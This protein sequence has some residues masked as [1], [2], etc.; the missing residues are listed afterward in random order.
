[1]KKA[2]SLMFLCIC[3]FIIYQYGVNFLKTTHTVTYNIKNEKDFKI[4]ESFKNKHYYYLITSGEYKFYFKE[5][6]LFNKTKHVIKDIYQKEENGMMCI[7][8]VYVKG[9]STIICSDKNTVYTYNSVKHNSL[10][11]L[12]YNELKNQGYTF[13][14]DELNNNYTQIGD[15]PQIKDNVTYYSKNF[16]DKENLVLWNYKGFTI[17]NKNRSLNVYPLSFDRYENTISTLISK[18]YITP[19][20][21]DNKLFNFNKVYIYDILTHKDYELDLGITLSNYTY[22]NGIVDNKLYLFDS[23]KIIQ[24]MIDPKEKEVEIVGDKEKNAIYYDGK[25]TERNIYDFVNKKIKFKIDDAQ[26][27]E[28]Y[29]YTLSYENIDSYFFY[30]GNKLYQVYKDMID[31]PILIVDNKNVKEIKIKN[32]NIYYILKDTVYKYELNKISV[33]LIK[34]NELLY[35]NYNMY[36]IYN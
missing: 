10:V 1:M 31:I 15:N 2:I 16:E 9:P 34:Y 11:S 26:L 18:Y 35:N 3:V 20:Y 27:K 21:Q 6:N 28:K 33:P 30:T 24:L 14:F 25:F 17:L 36:D 29:N 22:I 7:Y 12:F 32:D 13:E 23:S 5:K 19:V 8:P 4:E